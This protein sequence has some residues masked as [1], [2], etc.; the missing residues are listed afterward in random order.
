[1]E[2]IGVEE[3]EKVAIVLPNSLE[4][5]EAFLA[6]TTYGAVAVMVQ[7]AGPAAAK[8]EACRIAGCKKAFYP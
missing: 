8:E 5:I 1:M 4:C 6:V 3:Q 7:A 2:K